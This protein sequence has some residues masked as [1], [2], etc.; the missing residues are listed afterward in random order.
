MIKRDATLRSELHVPILP[1]QGRSDYCVPD[2]VACLHARGVP[3][4]LHA[5]ADYYLVMGGLSFTA[6]S[7]YGG[8][9]YPVATMLDVKGQRGEVARVC[10]L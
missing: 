4:R 10:R 8:A 5:G 6:G 1:T 9:W 3:V 7:P 2:A